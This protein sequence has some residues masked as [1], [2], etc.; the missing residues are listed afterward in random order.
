MENVD[1]FGRE[2]IVERKKIEVRNDAKVFFC[3]DEIRAG[4]MS[5]K[6]NETWLTGR[7]KEEE[8]GREMEELA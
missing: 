3:G 6:T 5:A 4:D 1:G 7:G 2:K 8:E